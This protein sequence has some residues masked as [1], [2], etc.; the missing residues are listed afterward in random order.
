MYPTIS[1]LQWRNRL[2]HGT[3]RQYLRHAG[4]VS[5][6]L[7]WS[8]I[9]LHFSFLECQANHRKQEMHWLS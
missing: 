3:Y 8:R 1:K 5:S 2:A 7:T 6:S 9:L 4:V